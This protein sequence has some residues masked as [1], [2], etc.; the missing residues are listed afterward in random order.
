MTEN[1]I[2]QIVQEKLVGH[3]VKKSNDGSLVLSDKKLFGMFV[4]LERSKRTADFDNVISV[5]NTIENYLTTIGKLHLM[6]FVYMYLKF[7]DFTPKRR[8]A[9]EVQP[10]GTVKKTCIYRRVVSD[11]EML[12]GL[13][14]SVKYD[15]LGERFLRI[16]YAS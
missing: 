10:D 13:W 14:A 7:S 5:A 2:Y 11:E 9:D 15:Q 16:V 4:D 6:A 8:K 3:G 1:S 12:I